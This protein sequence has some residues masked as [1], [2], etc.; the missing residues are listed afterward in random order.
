MK[1]ENKGLHFLLA[2]IVLILLSP[3]R[4]SAQN[5]VFKESFSSRDLSRWTGTLSDFSFSMQAN[6]TLL[7]LTADSAG[8]SQLF[9]PASEPYGIWEVYIELDFSPSSNNNLWIYLLSDQH[10]SSD[11]ANGYALKIGE[12]GSEDRVSLHK[13]I[14][15]SPGNIILQSTSVV[16]QG[17]PIRLRIERSRQGN[18]SLGLS[19]SYDQEPVVEAEGSD[20]EFTDA[21]WFGFIAKYT[22]S[23]TGAFKFDFSITPKP[24]QLQQLS[25]PRRDQISLLFNLPLNPELLTDAIFTT[26]IPSAI[27]T[28]TELI[29][30]DSLLLTFDAEF[31]SG[32]ASL[33]IRDLFAANGQSLSDTLISF[34]IF[35]KISP[36]DLLISEFMND[37]PPASPE[38]LEVYN[39]SNKYLNLS[40]IQIADNRS[41][42]STGTEEIIMSPG[43]FLIFTADSASLADVFGPGNYQNF[44]LPS[45]NNGSDEIRIYDAEHRLLD[46]LAYTDDWSIPDSSLERISY[47]VSAVYSENWQVSRSEYGG[48]PGQPNMVIPDTSPPQLLYMQYLSDRSLQVHFSERITYAEEY[49]EI[50]LSPTLMINNFSLQNNTLT[51]FTQESFVSGQSYELTISGITDIF[52]NMMLPA[53]ESIRYL[54]F[55]EV[56][57]GDININEFRYKGSTGE[58]IELYNNSNKNLDLS[59]WS[60]FNSSREIHILPERS[61]LA[62]DEYLITGDPH[63]IEDGGTSISLRESGDQIILKDRDGITIDRLEYDEYWTEPADGASLEKKDPVLPS[64][65]PSQ[66][67]V[68]ID[69][70]QSAGTENSVFEKDFDPPEIL[71]ARRTS[72]QSIEISFDEFIRKPESISV[73]GDPAELIRYDPDFASVI[74]I[75]TQV[76]SARKDEILGFSFLEDFKGNQSSIL[77]IG[78]IQ[79][80]KAGDLIINEVMFDPLVDPEDGIPDQAE[81][82]ELFNRQYFP[83]S[84]EELF[85]HHQ[86]DENGKITPMQSVDPDFKY[87]K[88]RSYFLFFADDTAKDISM[89]SLST[90]FD[91]SERSV[92]HSSVINRGS[93]GLSSDSD[94][95]YLSH[96][97][98]GSLD[99]LFYSSNWHNPNI[100]NTKG[101]SLERIST[102]VPTN[103]DDNW[104]SNTGVSGGTPLSPNSVW[105]EPGKDIQDNRV[106]VSPNPFSPDGDGFEDHTIISYSLQDQDHLLRVR[107]FD[108]Y[109]RFVRDLSS[110]QSAGMQGD[111]IWD[112]NDRNGQNCRAGLY[113][114]LFEATDQFNNRHFRVKKT[115]ALAARRSSTEGP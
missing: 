32:P 24:L 86:P 102:E 113:I 44:S 115:V 84:A 79:E 88:G 98:L 57:P 68:N 71:Y 66:W 109:G 100:Y 87:A 23:N 48:T 93:L 107:I 72:D 3:L 41:F 53:T 10:S 8:T 38:Y 39:H 1:R 37:P 95:I 89:S 76:R 30:S 50:E 19:R 51:L 91:L 13:I 11:T 43:S 25:V 69:G 56:L 16:A 96:H 62:P 31:P 33:R 58:F 63:S 4:I 74:E 54:K 22:S 55:S 6:N 49:P 65:D 46:S 114:I 83:I 90:Y 104:G 21:G 85:L 77:D 110:T 28:G 12:N 18:W 75:S 34:T 64:A 112:G 105:Q 108:R 60:L 27:L 9:A 26:D 106:S 15:G 81:Y 67:A 5:Y 52:G 45:L 17:G 59:R 40:G 101:I 94:Q 82:I 111:L 92:R 36:G 20:N 42:R 7:Q 80:L 103:R 78:V 29:S 35:D 14:S 73:D 97:L 99:S 61:Y 47:E 2:L 70:S